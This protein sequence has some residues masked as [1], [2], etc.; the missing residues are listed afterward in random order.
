MTYREVQ[1]SPWLLLA[2]EHR[3]RCWET[4]HCCMHDVSA[5]PVLAP[6][7]PPI[8]IPQ[9]DGTGGAAGVAIARGGAVGQDV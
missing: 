9:F 5:A 2:H 8:S 3:L 6:T 1:G 7:A 4:H